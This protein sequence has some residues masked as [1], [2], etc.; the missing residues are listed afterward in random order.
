MFKDIFIHTL[1]KY[2]SVIAAGDT[3]DLNLSITVLWF[4][5]GHSA[6]MVENQ[7]LREESANLK[8]RLVSTEESLKDVVETLSRSN[9]RKK[10]VERAICKQLHMTHDVLKKAKSHLKQANPLPQ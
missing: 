6:L 3:Y 1:N 4:D 8:V 5:A 9:Q 2:T 7:Q 10:N